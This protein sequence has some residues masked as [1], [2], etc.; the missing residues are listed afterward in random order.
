VNFAKHLTPGLCL[1]LLL[2][3]T[4]LLYLPGLKGNYILDDYANIVDNSKVQM[5]ELTLDQV[6]IALDSGVAS[7][8][9]RPLSMLSFA[10]NHRFTQMDPYYFKLTNLLIHL[11]TATGVYLLVRELARATSIAEVRDEQQIGYFA[12]FVTAL[13][14]LHPLN[15]STVLYVVQRM[16]QLATLIAVFTLYLY[17]HWRSQPISTLTRAFAILGSL[18]VLTV[19][20]ILGKENAVLIPLLL[21]CLEFFIFRFRANT[22]AERWF[23]RLLVFGSLVLPALGASLLLIIDPSQ[24]I[25]DYSVRSFTMGER[26]MTEGRVLWSYIGWLLFP[27]TVVLSFFHDDYTV[28]RALL[29]PPTTLLALAGLIALLTVLWRLRTTRPL[30][31]FGLVFF[32]FGHALESTFISL[33]LVFEHRNYLPGQGILLALGDTLTRLPRKYFQADSRKLTSSIILL[34]FGLGCSVEARKWSNTFEHVRHIVET[35]PKSHRANYM[36]G[37]LYGFAAPH[38]EDR[39]ES[40]RRARQFFMQSIPL[41]PFAVRGHLGYVLTQTALDGAIDLSIMQEMN[42]RLET[43]DLMRDGFAEISRITQCWHT[44]QCRFPI[45][46]LIEMYNSIGRNQ[47]V[48]PLII[49]GI[50]D[51]VG[52]AMVTNYDRL[53]DGKALLY[54]ARSKRNQVTIIDIKLIQLEAQTGNIEV[55]NQLIEAALAN[56]PGQLRTQLTDIKELLELQGAL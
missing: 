17:C 10:L 44:G 25:G 4:F 40:L 41:D 2:L 53:E 51:Q 26:I 23:L 50:L 45:N 48:D 20:G 15:V 9:K 46:Q 12:L 55:A 21:L 47:S 42:K 34:L 5:T 32:L 30:T 14:T 18:A 7:S 38:I 56:N 43:N 13:W 1:A 22:N 29:D 49:Q 54:L 24:L 27:T 52:S 35:H 6:N 33:E 11:L 28:S 39:D 31:S 37:L 16:T 8:I 36:L 19:L 3:L